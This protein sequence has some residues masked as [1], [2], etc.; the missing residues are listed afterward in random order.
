MAEE[1]RRFDLG[2]EAWL[3]SLPFFIDGKFI[4]R[5]ASLSRKNAF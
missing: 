5:P 3:L 4:G 1:Q 2:M